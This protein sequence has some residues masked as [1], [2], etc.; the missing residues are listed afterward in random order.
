MATTSVSCGWTAP[1]TAAG[2]VRAS[3]LT[4]PWDFSCDGF[5]LSVRSAD[6]PSR[7]AADVRAACG[8]TCVALTDGLEVRGL[9]VEGGGGHGAQGTARSVRVSDN[10]FAELGG[11]MLGPDARYGNGVEIWV[12]S[13]DVEVSRNVLHDI[14]DVAVTVQ[15]DRS[16]D[17]T[18]WANV[19]IAENLVYRCSQSVEFWSS[20]SAG[21]ATGFT[22]CTVEGNICLFAGQGWSGAVRRTRTPGSTSSPTGGRC[23]PTSG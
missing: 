1:C 9:R 2:S 8:E 22:R 3:Q 23:P 4:Q 17:A 16:G 10:E 19:S 14:Y 15:G 12:G 7:A 5:L 18:G 6:N 13:S 20:G 21:G 11:S